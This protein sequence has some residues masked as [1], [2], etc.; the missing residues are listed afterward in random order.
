MQL[1]EGESQYIKLDGIQRFKVNYNSFMD[2]GFVNPFILIEEMTRELIK[3][4]K[5]SYELVIRMMSHEVNNSVGA[6]NSVMQSVLTIDTSLNS[7][8]KQAIEISIDR[9]QSLNRF[10]SNFANVVK[11]PLPSFQEVNV[12]LIIEKVLSV[13]AQRFSSDIRVEFFS[14]NVVNINADPDQIEQ[15]LMNIIK[16]SIEAINNKGNIIIHLSDESLSIKDDG[17]GI[18]K[19]TQEKIFTPFFSTKEKGQGIGLTLVREI[20]LNHNFQFKLHRIKPNQTEFL[21]QFK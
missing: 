6:V 16:N 17:I 2:R 11:L 21:I 15:V 20:L 19:E 7:D 18:D 13:F 12:G 10:M 14:K 1:K 8:V 5:Q 9:N 4:E 3:T